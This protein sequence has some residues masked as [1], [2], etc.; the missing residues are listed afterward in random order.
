MMT[1]PP[2]D[3]MLGNLED[4]Y[5]PALIYLIQRIALSNKDEQQQVMKLMKQNAF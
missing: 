5:P 3:K 1:Y 2:S 4:Y